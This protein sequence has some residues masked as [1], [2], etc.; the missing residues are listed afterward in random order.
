MV[1]LQFFRVVCIWKHKSHCNIIYV[2]I[3]VMK[4]ERKKQLHQI[5][6]YHNNDYYNKKVGR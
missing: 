6:V 1:H 5:S 3:T 4:I 2:I